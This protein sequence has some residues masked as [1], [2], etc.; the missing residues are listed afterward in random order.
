[1][2]TYTSLPVLFFVIAAAIGLFLRWQF[3]LPTPGIRFTWFVHAHSHIMFLGWVTNVLYLASIRYLSDEDQKKAMRWF[4]VLQVLVVGMLIAFPLQGYALYS[5][6]FSTLHTLLLAFLIIV[7]WQ[8]TKTQHNTALAFLRPALVFF[9]LSTLGPFALGYFMSQG[10]STSVWYNFSIYYYLHFQYNGFFTL[11]ILALFFQLLDDYGITY[12]PK[13]ARRMALWLAIACVPAYALSVLFANP[14]LLFNITGGIAAMMQVGVVIVFTLDIGGSVR[15][16]QQKTGNGLYRVFFFVWLCWVVKSVLQLL[17]AHPEIARLAYEL[18]PIVIA[19][20][21]LVLLG[22]ITLFLLAW[23]VTQGWASARLSL[24]GI[25]LL[26][27][28]FIISEIVLIMTPWWGQITGGRLSHTVVVFFF[29][30]L[31]WMGALFSYAAAWKAT[32]K[33]D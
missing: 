7:F 5:I 28:G 6:T 14:G 4:V 19:Y 11:G 25:A 20:L 10:L 9:L 12:T 29:S 24:R 30:I 13:L 17:S 15:A 23:Y 1:M 21:H 32:Q 27:I 18:R 3:L 2:R 8:R 31:M 26:I 16:L 33:A 22:T